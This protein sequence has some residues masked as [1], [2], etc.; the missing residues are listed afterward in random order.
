MRKHAPLAATAQHIPD[1]VD[2]LTHVRRSGP[3]SRF[4]WRNQG[5][6][7]V[8]LFLDFHRLDSLS[9]SFST[10]FLTNHPCCLLFSPSFSPFS[11]ISPGFPG[12][13]TQLLVLT[14]QQ[15]VFKRDRDR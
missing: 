11:H 12:H 7:N 4:L 5:F 6:Q 1:R 10:S 14:G 2:H 3:S 13:F 8:P 15:A 9:F